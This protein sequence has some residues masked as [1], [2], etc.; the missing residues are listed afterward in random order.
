[1]ARAS[2]RVQDEAVRR[3]QAVLDD[4]DARR[5]EGV[6]L[7]DDVLRAEV[8][9]SESRDALVVAREGEYNAVARL[10]NAMGRNAG[11]PLEVVDLESQPPLPGA[12]ADL[13]EQAATQR[14]EVSV[15]RQAVKAAQEGRHAARGEFLPRIF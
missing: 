11:L 6:A 10:N 4:T 7:K 14:P 9:L 13:L 1:L 5:L 2:R 8:Q 12:L 3:A 15:V